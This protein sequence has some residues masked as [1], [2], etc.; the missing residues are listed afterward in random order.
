MKILIVGYYDV[1][2]SV[3]AA[4]VSLEGLGH[5][6]INYPMFQKVYDTHDKIPDYENDFMLC[7]NKCRPN[8][9]LWW[10]SR[11]PIE[12]YEKVSPTI[13]RLGIYTAIFNWDDP[14]AWLEPGTN[15]RGRSKYYDLAVTTCIASTKQ[16]I[17]HGSKNSVFAAPGADPKVFYP[18]D[19]TIEYKCDVSI[20][21][22]NLYQDT[23]YRYQYIRRKDIIDALYNDTSITFHIY[24]PK[25]LQGM[26]PKSYQGYANYGDL[27]GIFNTSRI[28]IS[29]HVCYN[30]DGYI[31]ERSITVLMSGG[32]LLID[33]V[34]GLS[35][36]MT[37]NKECIVMESDFMS[38][39]KGIL[40]M[41]DTEEGLAKLNT[42]KR[43]AR[44]LAS[45]QYTWDNWSD[46]LLSNIPKH[47]LSGS[48][49]GSPRKGSGQPKED[50]D[51]GKVLN[52]NDIT[53]SD[54]IT[55]VNGLKNLKADLSELDTVEGMVKSND[56]LDIKKILEHF[57]TWYASYV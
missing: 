44:S 24:G 8:V 23:Y 3:K 51:I 41:Y 47:V 46:I 45:K 35:K 52:D 54:Y 36:I 50:T 5:T 27:N 29:T 22:T 48:P 15:I 17:E 53:Y 34:K 1:K 43:N 9:V 40:S 25:F 13:T 28:N 38:Q 11:L 32:L 21:I 37:P 18:L 12:L 20:V 31:N 16:Y 39:I 55:L 19:S 49:G 30:Y 57:H 6:V 56:T 42:I 26:Y 10:F 7:I 2:D 33:P 4:V 14:W